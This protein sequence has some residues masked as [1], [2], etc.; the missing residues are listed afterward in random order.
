MQIPDEVAFKLLSV[1]K[2]A[3]HLAKDP[4]ARSPIAFGDAHDFPAAGDHAA[5][6]KH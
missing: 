2:L 3:E 4:L 6:A 5:P 1:E